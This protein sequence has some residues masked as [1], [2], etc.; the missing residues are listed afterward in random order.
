LR[1]KII[2]DI[3]TLIQSTLDRYQGTKRIC[4]EGIRCDAMVLGSLMIE[5]NRLGY[6]ISPKAP[7]NGLSI[8]NLVQELK[9]M[10]IRRFCKDPLVCNSRYSWPSCEEIEESLAKE[11][12]ELEDQ[13]VGLDR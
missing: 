11:L 13:V 10:D 2:S 1:Q 4:S 8:K 6:L 3:F 9:E 12:Q 5:L 7:F